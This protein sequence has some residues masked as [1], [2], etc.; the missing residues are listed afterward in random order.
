MQLPNYSVLTWYAMKV[1][2]I[3]N[4][5]SVQQNLYILLIY[6]VK[7]SGKLIEIEIVELVEQIDSTSF[8][9]IDRTPMV[10]EICVGGVPSPQLGWM[11]RFEICI[12]NLL[13]VSNIL[14]TFMIFF[15]Y[16]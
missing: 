6:Q 5:F 8:Y 12:W 15:Y 11:F 14:V 9:C 1:Y 4:Y 13:Y 16:G 3:Q 7:T 10:V 2:V